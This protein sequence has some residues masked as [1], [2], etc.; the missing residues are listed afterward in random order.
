[1]ARSARGYSDFC[2]NTS[3]FGTLL[4]AATTKVR[5]IIPARANMEAR[6]TGPGP[7]SCNAQ[8]KYPTANTRSRKIQDQIAF[9]SLADLPTLPCRISVDHNSFQ[10]QKSPTV[11]CFVSDRRACTSCWIT[12]NFPVLDHFKFPNTPVESSQDKMNFAVEPRFLWLL[13]MHSSLFL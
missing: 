7:G 8:I 2:D 3:K 5:R 12:S 10:S 6:T 13:A 9:R 11:I 4:K 1:M